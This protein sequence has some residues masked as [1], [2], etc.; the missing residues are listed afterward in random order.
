MLRANYELPSVNLD[1]QKQPMAP[2]A[3]LKWNSEFKEFIK[4][5]EQQGSSSLRAP[6]QFLLDR[7]RRFRRLPRDRQVIVVT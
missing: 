5:T 3:D 7:D 4:A 2:T 6:P 1:N